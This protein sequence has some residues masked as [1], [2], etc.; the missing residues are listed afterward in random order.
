MQINNY[1]YDFFLCKCLKKKKKNS[2]I[3]RPESNVY[4]E[5]CS[6]QPAVYWL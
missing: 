6:N 3:L 5:G 4:L 1:N 2:C